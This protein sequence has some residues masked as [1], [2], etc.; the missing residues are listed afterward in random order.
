MDRFQKLVSEALRKDATGAHPDPNLLTAFAEKVLPRKERDSMLQHL[1]ACPDCRETVYLA[2]PH[3]DD[4]QTVVQPPHRFRLLIRWGAAAASVAILAV[5]FGGRYTA[6]KLAAPAPVQVA[7][8]Q[9]PREFDR[10]PSSNQATPMRQGTRSAPARPL[11]KHMTARPEARLRFD[12]SGQVHVAP[13]SPAPQTFSTQPENKKEALADSKNLNRRVAADRD[14]AAANAIK[15]TNESLAV[16]GSAGALAKDGELKRVPAAQNAPA[17]GY[18]AVSAIDK[19]AVPQW[20]LAREGGIERSIDSGKTWNP[21]SVAAGAVLKALSASGG[22][23]WTGGKDGALFH[24]PNAGAD[25][26][27]V[28]PEFAGQKLAGDITR[29]NFSDP[30]NGAVYTESGETWA[31]SD[32]GSSWSRK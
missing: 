3:S 9:Q 6:R 29:I 32:G 27:Q 17:A 4:A 21:V 12:E 5:M 2:A 26:V 28:H 15:S 23:V 14:L 31:T 8:E 1:A 24:S 11:E 25:W 16:S 10:L 19:V 22:S 7:A 18:D 13:P 20:R 30:L